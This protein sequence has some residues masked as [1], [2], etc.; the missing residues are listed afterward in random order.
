MKILL[1]AFTVVAG[2][3]FGLQ[4]T[5]QAPSTVTGT[6][7]DGTAFSGTTRRGA[8]RDHGGVQAFSPAVT[9]PAT[10]SAP[11][12]SSSARKAPAP[13]SQAAPGGATGQVWVNTKSKVY[14]CQGDRYY[15]KTK[16]GA[17]MTETAA[18]AEGDRPDHGK[19]CS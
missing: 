10:S 11:P 2:L 7:K 16:A 14:H 15:G 18:K 19:A 4:A 5:A 9:A 17:Y 8:C 12:T 13:A 1:L 6:C 3:G